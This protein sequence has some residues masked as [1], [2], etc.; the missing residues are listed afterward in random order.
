MMILHKFGVMKKTHSIFLS[1]LSLLGLM[2]YPQSLR[3]FSGLSLTTR[4]TFVTTSASSTSFATLVWDTKPS[5]G[6]RTTRLHV[7]HTA[8]PVTTATTAESTS[9]ASTTV[10]HIL[11]LIAETVDPQQS[12]SQARISQ[13]LH[14]L[15]QQASPSEYATLFAIGQKVYG[16]QGPWDTSASSS[17]TA[18][19]STSMSNDP[20]STKKSSTTTSDTTT[21]S[22]IVSFDWMYTF[23]KDVFQCYGLT[24]AQA[25]TCAD[26]LVEADRRGIHSHG[27]GR[28]KPIYCDRIDRG[29]IQPHAQLTTLSESPT[30]ALLDGHGGLGLLLGP[31]AMQLAIDKAKEYGV[32]FVAVRNSTH[33]G[34]AGYYVTMA[35]AQGCIGWTGTNA[36][37]SIAPTHGVEPMLGTNPL[38]FGIPSDE[39]FDFVIDCA[40]SVNQRGKLEQY[41][42]AQQATPRGCVIDQH[43]NERTDTEAILKELVQG[44]CALTP[45]G[46]AGE[47]MGGYK[48]YGWATTVELLSTAFQSGPFGAALSGVNPTSGQPQAM[49]LGHYF[50]AI[51]I[52]KLCPL[53]TFQSNVG[54]LL[55]GLRG[56]RLSPQGAGRIWTAGEK[57]YEARVEQMAQGGMEVPP[58]L[59]QVMRDL[60]QAR[61]G[62]RDKYPRFPFEPDGDAPPAVSSP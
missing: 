9:S 26:V 49:P 56:S 15:A 2:L 4:N 35:T 14:D 22:V 51:D 55:R 19:V 37:P 60:R 28:L 16:V 5:F 39:D 50:L 24:E 57:E 8:S 53:E 17:S 40:T 29:L 52:E 18:E 38:C 44:T 54:R 23:I 42:R 13:L 41:E 31:Q 20:S 46:G 62:L 32:G 21:N 3:A 61:P 25:H 34:I 48:G 7:T 58:P 36:R 11:Q 47:D 59:Q 45:M 43:G 33:Y 12:E 1:P 10:S 30:T 27:L 6:R